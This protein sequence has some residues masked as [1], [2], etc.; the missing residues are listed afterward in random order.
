M[1][2]HEFMFFG[3][4]YSGI[5][6]GSK[7]RQPNALE[8]AH[9]FVNHVLQHTLERC[10]HIDPTVTIIFR[11]RV[12]HIVDIGQFMMRNVKHGVSK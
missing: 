8:D 3:G 5:M 7:A 11:P 6:N 10:R 12:L 2:I 9:R 1:Q 4:D